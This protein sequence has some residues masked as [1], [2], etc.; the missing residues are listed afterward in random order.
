K[1][2]GWLSLYK[3]DK[4]NEEAEEE[5]DLADTD[6]RALNES[7]NGKCVDAVTEQK[8][9]QQPKL[10]TMTTLLV[11]LTKVAKYVKNPKL[12]KILKD[13]DKDKAG[14]HGGIGTPA[15]RSSIIET[16]F[17]RGYLAEHKKSV[18]STPL[19]QKLYE[20]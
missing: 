5:K 12:A 17:K 19:G 18:I 14:E 8:E 4:G 7:S 11:D 9:T 16:L 20:I 13:K 10:Y 3:N 2:L 6:L 1:S 15:T